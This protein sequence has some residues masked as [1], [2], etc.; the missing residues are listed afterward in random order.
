MKKML[1]CVLSSVASLPVMASDNGFYAGLSL[2][3]ANMDAPSVFGSINDDKTTVAG[4]FAGYQLN[5]TWSVE[6]EFTGA[7]KFET[8]TAEGKADT[9]RLSAVAT[10]PLADALSMYGRLGVA[11]AFGQGKGVADDKNRTAPTFGIGVQYDLKPE[12]SVLAGW[13]RYKA[14]IS[15]KTNTEHNY[16]SDVFSVAGI[17]RF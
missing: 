13:D 1:I 15:T 9:L 4:A 17:Y 8:D 5:S 10:L 11:E 2:G 7:G 16:D 3:Y 12:V 14:A 6:A